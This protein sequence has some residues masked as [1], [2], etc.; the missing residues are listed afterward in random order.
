MPHA[1]VR[2]AGHTQPQGEELASYTPGAVEEDQRTVDPMLA[3]VARATVDLAVQDEATCARQQPKRA[4]AKG[5][6]SG[7][8]DSW[9]SLGVPK[10][11]GAGPC[12]PHTVA[13]SHRVQLRESRG[14]PRARSR[15]ADGTSARTQSRPIR[16]ACMSVWPCNASAGGASG[17][18]AVATM[19]ASSCHSGLVQISHLRPATVAQMMRAGCRRTDRTRYGSGKG[20]RLMAHCGA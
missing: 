5:P 7:R 6:S 15:H 12:T 1:N 9:T 11:G 13:P 10:E 14:S 8:G 2:L 3:S 16:C 18:V 17:T 19:P 4:V 20:C